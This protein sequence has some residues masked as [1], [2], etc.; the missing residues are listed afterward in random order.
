VN[1]DKLFQVEIWPQTERG[2]TASATLDLPAYPWA[3]LDAMDR[4]RIRPGE[5]FNC[6]LLDTEVD[7][8]RN[9]LPDN[10]NLNAL[11]HL[12]SR[13][14]GMEDWERLAMEG[15][16]QIAYGVSNDRGLGQVSDESGMLPE[17]D[18]V[19]EKVRDLIDLE[20]FGRKCRLAEGGVFARGGYV[21]PDG[22]LQQA[23]PDLRLDIQR[24]DYQILLEQADG[25]QLKLPSQD[26]LL[27]VYHACLDCRIPQLMAGIDIENIEDTNEFA[28]KLQDMGD[29]Q[30]QK[31]KALLTAT[32]C[33]SLTEANYLAD[34]LEL[35]AFDGNYAS[36]EEYAMRELREGFP[37]MSDAT[38]RNCV[39][40]GRFGSALLRQEQTAATAYGLICR[41]DGQQITEREGADSLGFDLT[42]E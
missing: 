20:L 31:F 1:A 22:E 42:M 10:P 11:N 21:V 33:T 29:K 24:P 34:N 25:R 13:I 36:P 28:E 3:I 18:D 35:Y 9:R 14:A 4:A 41:E 6:E 23:Y 37:S 30:V 2:Y 7:F 19:P 5:E 15:M 17:L 27:A 12:A 40:L 8:L 32:G 39:N 26:E 38:L 16:C